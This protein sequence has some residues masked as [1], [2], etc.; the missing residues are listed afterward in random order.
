MSH[1][2]RDARNDVDGDPFIGLFEPHDIARDLVPHAHHVEVRPTRRGDDV[3][4]RWDRTGKDHVEVSGNAEIRVI[5]IEARRAIGGYVSAKHQSLTLKIFGIIIEEEDLW[6]RKREVDVV[7]H[8]GR[9][10]GDE[11]TRGITL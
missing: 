10:P 5:I 6:S 4:A 9:D 1:D 7:H 11:R 3:D 8:H 2:E